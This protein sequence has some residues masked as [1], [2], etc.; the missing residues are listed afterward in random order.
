MNFKLPDQCNRNGQKELF[1]TG[2]RV[3]LPYIK[4]FF[5]KRKSSRR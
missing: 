2:A 4:T 3:S 1:K 5:K